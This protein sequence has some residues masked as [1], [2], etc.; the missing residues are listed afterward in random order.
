MCTPSSDEACE[1]DLPNLRAALD[2]L[3]ASGDAA[4]FQELAGALWLFWWVRGHYDEARRRMER[5]LARGADAPAAATAKALL[6]TGWLAHTRA[7]LA[8]A[9]ERFAAGLAI[10]RRPDRAAAA[11]AESLATIR[12]VGAPSQLFHCL[13]VLARLAAGLGQPEAAAKLL[14]AA[15][16]LGQTLG[17]GVTASHQADHERDAVALRAR[18]GPTAFAAAWQAGEGLAIEDAIDEGIAV[19]RAL[20]SDPPPAAGAGPADGLTR[21]E[22]EVLHLLVAGR[23]N[24]EIA[25]A[26]F[27]SER[28]TENHVQHIRAKLGVASRT[29]AAVFAVRH[30]LI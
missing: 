22:R 17:M 3:D 26:L 10:A 13:F 7:D 30:G 2:W 4:T 21:R 18:L 6:A 27:I 5:A 14:G 11:I 8:Q 24:A 16:A 20:G 29:E 19:A 25:S 23:S 28:T 1:A 9:T 12:A 15:T